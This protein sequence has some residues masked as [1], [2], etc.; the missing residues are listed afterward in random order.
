MGL[1]P[2]TSAF[3]HTH[4]HTHTVGDSISESSKETHTHEHVH[5]NKSDTSYTDEGHVHS[6][7]YGP[8]LGGPFYRNNDPT[9]D[10][11]SETESGYFNADSSNAAPASGSGTP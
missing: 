7:A 1:I 3:T 6:H 11:D 8:I 4:A 9:H 5:E 10:G 2:G